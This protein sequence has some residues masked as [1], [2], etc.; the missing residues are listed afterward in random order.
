MVMFTDTSQGAPAEWRWDFG[1]GFTAEGPKVMH[2]YMSAGTYTV[3]LLVI[4]KQGAQDTATFTNAISVSSNPFMP[5]FAPITPISPS[6]SADFTA[7][8]LSGPVPLSVR[9]TDMSKGNPATY[10]WNF[11]DGATSGEKNPIHVY[12]TPGKYTVKL[13]IARDSSTGQSERKDYIEVTAGSAPVAAPADEQVPEGQEPVTPET[14]PTG[15]TVQPEDTGAPY[16]PEDTGPVET[17]DEHPPVV[18][19][20][21]ECALALSLAQNAPSVQ[22]GEEFTV[23]VSGKPFEKVYVWISPV[24]EEE[25]AAPVSAG[26]VDTGDMKEEE[27]VQYSYYFGAAEKGVASAPYIID[28]TVLFDDPKGPYTIQE[29]VTDSVT[30]LTIFQQIP[31]DTGGDA[32]RYYGIVALDKNGEHDLV[33]ASD[34]SALGTY[35]IHAMSSDETSEL[36][37]TGMVQVVI[38]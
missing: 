18:T 37:C 31:Q 20:S 11:G 7:T 9:F 13:N 14:E 28:E 4:D 34:Q 23:K 24:Q 21:K 38:G 25:E 36:K 32:T 15:Q 16:V 29:V 10:E 17:A 5:G 30:G 3:T 33:L 26:A 12:T 22:P 1:D 27:N 19:E 35:T 2:S 6:F 8:P